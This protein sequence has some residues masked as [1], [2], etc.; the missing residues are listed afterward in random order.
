MFDYT[1]GDAG[2]T[3]TGFDL[4]EIKKRFGCPFGELENEIKAVAIFYV[5]ARR[6]DSSFSYEQ[7]MSTDFTTIK[8]AFKP[9][10]DATF[11]GDGT[12]A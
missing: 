2:N 5:H 8:D 9:M 10:D 1:M 3:L 4:V 11:P 6:Q 7:A 12:G